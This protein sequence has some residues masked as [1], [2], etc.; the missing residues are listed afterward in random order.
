MF[1]SYFN[2]HSR[3]E[4][5]TSTLWAG[6]PEPR[7]FSMS[8]NPEPQAKISVSGSHFRCTG[9]CK[10]HFRFERISPKC[11]E[12]NFKGSPSKHFWY[13]MWLRVQKIYIW[14]SLVLQNQLGAWVLRLGHSYSRYLLALGRRH[15]SSIFHCKI[16][17]IQTGKTSRVSW[18]Q[19][20]IAQ[21]NSK[22]K[23]DYST[24]RISQQVQV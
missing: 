11:A 15:T 16:D 2:S 23:R 19:F 24:Q 1:I 6:F 3:S 21:K 8:E 7:W 17:R 9:V 18:R 5:L 13:I 4:K 10:L 20:Q 14:G 22:K 12:W